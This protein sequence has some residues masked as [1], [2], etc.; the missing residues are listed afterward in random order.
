[1]NLDLWKGEV[2]DWTI[3]AGPEFKLSASV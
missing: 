2:R 3:D 1:M